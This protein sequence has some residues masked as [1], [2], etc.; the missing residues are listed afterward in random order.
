MITS[1]VAK[2]TFVV[3]EKTFQVMVITASVVKIIL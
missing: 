2:I 1:S 3:A